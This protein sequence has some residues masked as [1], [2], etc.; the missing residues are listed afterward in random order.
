MDAVGGHSM[1]FE[2]QACMCSSRYDS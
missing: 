1:N 2:Q